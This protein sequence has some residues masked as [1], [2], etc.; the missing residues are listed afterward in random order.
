MYQAVN[1]ERAFILT[2]LQ[3][4]SIS[5]YESLKACSAWTQDQIDALDKYEL[6]E[7]LAQDWKRDKHR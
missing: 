1:D 6:R 2:Q 5:E 4:L 3:T 7:H